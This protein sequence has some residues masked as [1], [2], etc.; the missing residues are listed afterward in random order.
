MRRFTLR[1]TDPQFKAIIDYR[2]KHKEFAT[3]SQ[4]FRNLIQLGL[5]KED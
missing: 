5:V 3:L 1:L 4:A 2:A